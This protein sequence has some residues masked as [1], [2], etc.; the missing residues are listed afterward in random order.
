MISSFDALFEGM[1]DLDGRAQTATS[2]NAAET[3]NVKFS[4]TIP[5]RPI[6]PISVRL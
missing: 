5:T 2:P 6:S 3:H 1:G 4:A